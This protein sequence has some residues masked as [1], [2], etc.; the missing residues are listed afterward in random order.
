MHPEEIKAALRMKGCTQAR[1]AE[2]LRIGR[3]TVSQVIA[4]YCKSS[5]VQKAIAKI[6]GKTIR[7]IWPNQVILRRRRDT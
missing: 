5:H 6:I 4:G 3:S 1:L 7:E 2:S